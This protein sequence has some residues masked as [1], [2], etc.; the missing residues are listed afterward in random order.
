M[1]PQKIRINKR[2]L[3][4]ALASTNPNEKKDKCIEVI[5]PKRIRILTKISTQIVEEDS[6]MVEETRESGLS[7]EVQNKNEEKNLE[8]SN[9]E[10]ELAQKISISSRKEE[11]SVPARKT[12]DILA[13]FNQLKEKEK[14]LFNRQRETEYL[15]HQKLTADDQRRLEGVDKEQEKLNIDIINKINQEYERATPVNLSGQAVEMCN[16]EVFLK[17][18][19]GDKIHWLEPEKQ[20][21]IGN[22]FRPILEP[23]LRKNHILQ[24]QCTHKNW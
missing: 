22:Y 20:K 16:L 7:V 11:I 19:L 18:Q 13:Q 17:A 8:K 15:P 1:K 23:L 4:I 14:M 24:Q 10:E 2:K 12:S 3:A 9:L 21:L 6:D 5:K